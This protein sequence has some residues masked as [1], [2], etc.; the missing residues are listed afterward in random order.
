MLTLQPNDKIVM[1]GDSIT[2]GVG[3]GTWYGPWLTSVDATYT[4]TGT[5]FTSSLA[6]A[7]TKLAT[8]TVSAHWAP[9]NFSPTVINKGVVGNTVGQMLARVNADVIANSPTVVIVEG[10]IND[11][12]NGTDLT[13][14]TSNVVALISAIQVGLPGV[15]MMWIGCFC[16]GEQFPDPQ[17]ALINSYNA[18]IVTACANASVTYMDIR[19]PQQAYEQANNVPPPGVISGVLCLDGVGNGV[20]PNDTLGIPLWSSTALALTNITGAPT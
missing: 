14:F 4:R 9:S 5:A 10:G 11:A 18:P 8:A 16:Y 3:D 15:R 7:T 13:T 19:T 6:T 20:H 12:V 17:N 1:L 2:A